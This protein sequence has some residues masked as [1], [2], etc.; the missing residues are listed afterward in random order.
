MIQLRSVTIY[1]S[2]NYP[3]TR[4][5]LISGDDKL[6]DFDT[7]PYRRMNITII[8]TGIAGMSAA[9]L[10]NKGHKIR[11]YKKNNRIGGHSNT[12]EVYTGQGTVTVDT[13]FRVYNE[14]NYPNLL[15]LFDHLGVSTKDAK[16]SFGASLDRG[17][18]E[19]SGTNLNGILDNASTCFSSD[20]SA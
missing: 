20:F 6:N 16:M 7:T 2:C 17:G 19:Y 1:C 15:A 8:G 18:L 11:L 3:P 10:L 4:Q 13:G 12:V 5:N 14:R 9:W